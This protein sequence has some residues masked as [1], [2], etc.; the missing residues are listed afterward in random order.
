MI[1]RR[2]RPALLLALLVACESPPR[3]SIEPAP[4][5]LA[6]T[7]ATA[8][9]SALASVPSSAVVLSVPLPVASSAPV[10]PKASTKVPDKALDAAFLA[11][12][13]DGILAEGVADSVIGVGLSSPVLMISEGSEPREPLRYAFAANATQTTLMRTTTKLS[14]GGQSVELPLVEMTLELKSSEKAADGGMPVT[15]TLTNVKVKANQDPQQQ[16][17]EKAMAPGLESVKGLRVSYTVDALGKA[18]NV[19]LQSPP[20]ANGAA[21]KLIEE[22]RRS[23]ESLVPPVPEAAVGEGAEWQVIQRVNAGVD[24]LMW[25]NYKLLKRKGDKIKL[26]ATVMQLA[27]SSKLQVGPGGPPT[28]VTLLAYEAGGV[29]ETS[30]SLTSLV[31]DAGVGSVKNLVRFQEKDKPITTET[32]VKLEFLRK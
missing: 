9:A 17:I 21:Q 27:A 23:F 11:K 18:S 7:S 26:S 14:G 32:A 5:Q 1:F 3:A 28:P 20:G 31:P 22:M 13:K 4:S 6:S 16:Q 12:A 2:V 25:T 15:G 24:T 30:T 19:Q 8:S 10:V 29:A